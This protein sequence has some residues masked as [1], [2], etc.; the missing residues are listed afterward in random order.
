[1]FFNFI[2]P[3]NI[4]PQG[5]LK[6]QL[7]IQA[8]GLHGNLDKVWRDVRDT[9]WLGG[10]GEGWERF[11]YFLDGFIPLAYLLGDKDKIERANKYAKALIQAQNNQGFFSPIIDDVQNDDLWSQFLIL[12]VITVYGDF[13]NDKKAIDA[14]YKGLKYLNDYMCKKTLYN[15][16]AARWFECLIPIIWLYQKRKEEWLIDM[17][18]RLKMYGLDYGEAL[19][20]WDKVN[21][22]WNYECHVVN[23]AMALKCE[24]LYCEITKEKMSNLAEK[25]I[26]ILDKYHG[27]AYGHFSGDECLS[28]NSPIQG[29]E[30]CGIVEAMYSYEWLIAITGNSQW[31]DA[32]E[33]LAYNALPAAISTDMWTHQYDQQ[34]NQ[35]ACIP[36]VKQ[37]FRTNNNEANLFGL[38]PHFGCCT[39]N[40][41]Q[42]FPKLALSAYM[43]KNNDLVVISPLPM[44]VSING[45][46]VICQSEYP[47]RDHFTLIS[48]DK[49]K[50]YIRIPQWTIPQCNKTFLVDDEYMVVE[51]EKDE[52]IDVIF[53]RKVI[54]KDRPNNQK[55]LYYGPLLFALPIEYKM[56][57]NEYIKDGVERKYPYCD[58]EI[59][60][61]GEWRY[62]LAGDE[63]IVKEY[64]YL[65][66][67]DRE[68]PPIKIEGIFAPVKWEYEKDMELVA[69]SI[70]NNKRNGPNVKLYMQPYGATYLRITEMSKIK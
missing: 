13:S 46:K 67:F 53:P 66:P 50:A 70:A 63:F 43:Q 7:E 33:K 25:T 41:G 65:C 24:A 54:I 4:K 45:I 36:F 12:K 19:K 39:A 60:P 23:I 15:W 17:A 29:S 55:C 64:P 1:M 3:L 69:S 30:L 28:G 42:G 5:W 68:N 44:E 14:V 57:M 35:I 18:R 51:L 26:E 11:P 37:P 34:V 62:A 40:F 6:R 2:N 58:Y 9:K 22:N 27:T 61:I 59:Y 8:N 10:E 31:G 56:Q 16:A 21:D 49:I 38:E 52:K 47:F 20:L 48:E 32:L